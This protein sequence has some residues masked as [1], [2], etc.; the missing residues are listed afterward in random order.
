MHELSIAQNLVELVIEA[1]ENTG[2]KRVHSVYLKLGVLSGVARE[3]LEFSF[4]V[5][6]QGTPLEGAKLVI[7]DVPVKVFCPACQEAHVLPEPFPMRCP[8]CGT[9]TSQV[10]E[11]LEMELFSLKGV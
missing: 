11:G 10:L 5:V 2:M 1:A 8:V 4:D 9:R 3:A 6:I 7:E